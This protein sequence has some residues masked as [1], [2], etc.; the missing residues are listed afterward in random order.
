MK[1]D[2]IKDTE[3]H[4]S[5]AAVEEAGLRSIQ[6]ESVLLV[7]R[8]MILARS[9]PVALNLVPV[10]INQDM[11]GLVPRIADVTGRYLWATLYLARS[12]LLTLVRT[13][14]HGTRK[15]DTPDLLNVRV[16]VPPVE[17]RCVVEDAVRA[18]EV[19]LEKRRHARLR[20]SQLFST[21][22]QGAF[23]GTLTASWR[24]GRMK[25]LLQEMEQQAKLLDSVSPAAG[26][27]D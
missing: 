19:N 26:D 20:I 17:R 16:M 21:L 5:E 18:R 13:A 23:S 8:G 25:E 2:F 15:L 3:D 9:V 11:K 22:L 6:A 1:N 27:A 7:V 12:R 4:V 10:T 14:A 24:Q